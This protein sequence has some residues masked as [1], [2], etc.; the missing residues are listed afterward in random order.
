MVSFSPSRALSDVLASPREREAI[1]DLLHE[2]DEPPP[3]L[4]APAPRRAA[5]VPGRR[6]LDVGD[7]TYV[8]AS[9]IVAVVPFVVPVG[10]QRT[11]VTSGMKTRILLVDGREVYTRAP[12]R[13]VMALW[14][15]AVS[16]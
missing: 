12:S 8:L 7:G 14:E 1:R 15:A 11:P 10:Y 3:H 4:S 13:E 5:A 6:I 9:Q 16:G 2:I